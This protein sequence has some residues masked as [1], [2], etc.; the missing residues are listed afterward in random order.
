MGAAFGLLALLGLG[1][2]KTDVGAHIFGF[3]WGLVLG[4]G[5]GVLLIRRGVPGR[6][7]QAALG[8]LA[9]LLVAGSWL[10]AHGTG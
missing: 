4:S 6:A 1:G 8:G 2:D 3:F 9:G 10:A 7:A 5:A